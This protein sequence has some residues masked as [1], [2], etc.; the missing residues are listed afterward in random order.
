[1]LS[2]IL[3]ITLQAYYHQHWLLDEETKKLLSEN[4]TRHNNK[5]ES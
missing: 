5:K 2:L 3:L 1:M 4:K